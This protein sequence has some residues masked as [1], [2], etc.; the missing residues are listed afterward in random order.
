MK[1]INAIIFHAISFGCVNKLFFPQSK[2]E[3]KRKEIAQRHVKEAK[4]TYLNSLQ[5]GRFGKN[6]RKKK[7]QT[8]VGRLPAMDVKG[9]SEPNN[10]KSN[11]IF[12]S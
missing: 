6:K 8:S 5:I 11:N 4:R 9:S 10:E 2:K 3:K 12:I 7:N 1:L